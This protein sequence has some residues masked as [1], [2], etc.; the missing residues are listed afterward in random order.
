MWYEQTGV[1][2]FTG[3]SGLP[4]GSGNNNVGS[5]INGEGAT[6]A[7]INNDGYI[8]LIFADETDDVSPS[9]TIFLGGAGSQTRSYTE[10]NTPNITSPI[11][12]LPVDVSGHEN[13]EWTWGD[14]DN[15]GDLDLFL[16]GGNTVG[17]WTQTSPGV[18]SNAD[19]HGV[20][21]TATTDGA[22]W[23]DFD[24]TGTLDLIVSKAASTTLY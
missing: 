15:D 7:D 1:N 17:L 18:Y 16:S 21:I 11:S 22:D 20:T 4:D 6:A 9:Y 12:G 8:D 14:Y 3:R 13:H 2:T 5:A 24:N 19:N 10:D 23:G